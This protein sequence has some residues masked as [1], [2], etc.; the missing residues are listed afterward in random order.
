M[1]DGKGKRLQTPKHRSGIFGD[2]SARFAHDEDHKDHP[3]HAHETS[4]SD[5]EEKRRSGKRSKATGTRSIIHFFLLHEAGSATGSESLMR[6]A[7]SG[8]WVLVQG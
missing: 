5:R 3:M 1:F 7:R 2:G 4:Q 6:E 8:E